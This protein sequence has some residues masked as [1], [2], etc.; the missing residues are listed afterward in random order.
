MFVNR[1]EFNK[2]RILRDENKMLQKGKDKSFSNMDFF[3]KKHA[4]NRL[5]KMSD[6]AED[7]VNELFQVN[8]NVK[9]P[10]PIKSEGYKILGI[11]LFCYA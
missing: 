3:E 6:I 10:L 8:H 4:I 7:N 5:F 9:I 1:Q 11:F 2:I